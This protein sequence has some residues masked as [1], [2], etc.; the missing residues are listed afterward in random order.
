MKN[1]HF[2]Q[3]ISRFISETI[4][5]MVIV[6][7]EDQ[8]VHICDLSNGAISNYFELD[9]PLTYTVSQK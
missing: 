7:I 1:W 3:Q 8:K 5:D 2:W 9:L 4:Q 6:T